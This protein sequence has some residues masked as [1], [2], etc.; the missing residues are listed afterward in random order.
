VALQLPAIAGPAFDA[1]DEDAFLVT[2]HRAL[3]SAIAAAG[4]TAAAVSGP[5]WTQT[6]E[7]KMDEQL[8]SGVH[9]LAVDPLHTGALTQDRYA[10]AMIARLQEIVAA[11]QIAALKSR[12]Q[13]I[14]PQEQPDDHAR[15]FGELIA[16]ESYHRNLRERSIGAQ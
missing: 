3:R 13:R 12:L 8:R 1:L 5:A 2:A 14:N 11:R 6:V 4:G 9:A 10:D 7:E 15:L 16:L